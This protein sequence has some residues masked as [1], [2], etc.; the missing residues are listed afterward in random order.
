MHGTFLHT[1]KVVLAATALALF[2]AALSSLG[3]FPASPA[4]DAGTDDNVSGFAWSSNIGW[5]SFNCATPDAG[6]CNPDYGV[7]VAPP[8]GTSPRPLSG[9]AWNSAIGWIS[10]NQT[11]TSGFPQSPQHGARLNADDTVTGWAR[12][13]AVFENECSGDLKSDTARGGW[14]G[15]IKMSKDASDTGANYGVTYDSTSGEFDGHAWGGD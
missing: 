10:F 11:Q 15:W 4:A 1:A 9:H 8:D 6:D 3:G 2:V 14:D 5:I 12:A 7:A 13:C